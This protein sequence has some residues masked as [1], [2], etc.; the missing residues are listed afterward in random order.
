MPIKRLR[1][2]VTPIKLALTSK[3]S[4]IGNLGRT[5][6]SNS[7]QKLQCQYSSRHHNATQKVWKTEK[8]AAASSANSAPNVGIWVLNVFFP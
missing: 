1:I 6:T 3:L 5:T 8:G 4:S 2:S 7:V